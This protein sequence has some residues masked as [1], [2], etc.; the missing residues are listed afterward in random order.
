MNVL[1][2]RVGVDHSTGGGGWNAPVDSA[3]REYAYVTI[4]ESHSVHPG[5]DRPYA[6]LAR[7]LER[8]GVGLPRHLLQQ[9]MHL[10]PDF[11]HLTYGDQGECAMQLA[12]FQ[13][14]H[15]IVFYSGM[16][17]VATGKLVYALIGLLVVASWISAHDVRP[18][19]RVQIAHSRREDRG[20]TDMIWRDLSGVSGRLRRCFPI[21][22]CRGGAYRVARDLLSAW[23]GLSV[24]DGYIQRNARLPRSLDPGRFLK[25]FH[26]LKPELIQVNN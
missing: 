10:D 20:L 18:E 11:K 26:A 14:G 13:E 2:V 22:G 21:G 16:K 9:R 3:L 1:L 4:P 19:D 12:T 15:H 5:M 23:D 17:D 6:A 8:L 24:K 25:W 7:A